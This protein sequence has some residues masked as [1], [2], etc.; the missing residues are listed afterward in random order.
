MAAG[1]EPKAP[2]LGAGP[3]DAHVPAEPN[4]LRL[5]AFELSGYRVEAHSMRFPSIR[6]AADAVAYRP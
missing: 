3:C 2:L 4:A 1:L 5:D 6:A